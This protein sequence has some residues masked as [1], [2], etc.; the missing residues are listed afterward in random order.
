MPSAKRSKPESLL[1]SIPDPDTIRSWLSEAIRQ[2][3]LLRGLL[4]VAQRK[5]SY[6]NRAPARPEAV[7][8]E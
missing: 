4:R 8:G 7:D 1:T 6:Q 5:A 3:A 2:A